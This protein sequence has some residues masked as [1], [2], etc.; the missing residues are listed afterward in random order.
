ME[1]G[2]SSGTHGGLL[3]FDRI[4]ALSSDFAIVVHVPHGW[5]MRERERARCESKSTCGYRRRQRAS[6]DLPLRLQLLLSTRRSLENTS[7]LSRTCPPKHPF[8]Q[9][10]ACSSR[11]SQL[12]PTPPS[13]SGKVGRARGSLPESSFPSLKSTP[14]RLPFAQNAKAACCTLSVSQCATSRRRRSKNLA[15]QSPFVTNCLLA[16]LICTFQ[17]P[18]PPPP[19]PQKSGTSKGLVSSLS[20]P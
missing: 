5:S 11:C 7:L 19:P 10:S 2:G 13:E 18:P 6:P 1:Q 12:P 20:L 4:D 3:A 17:V 9:R 15:S 14:P 8:K 16:C